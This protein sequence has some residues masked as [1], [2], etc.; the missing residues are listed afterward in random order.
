MDIIEIE[1]D[2]IAAAFE[3][4]VDDGCAPVSPGTSD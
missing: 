1:S 3:D 4:R 2:N